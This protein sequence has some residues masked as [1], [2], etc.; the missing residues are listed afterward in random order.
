ML[1]KNILLKNFSFESG[2]NHTINDYIYSEYENGVSVGKLL[3]KSLAL[4]MI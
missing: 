3:K 4:S 2:K 1:K